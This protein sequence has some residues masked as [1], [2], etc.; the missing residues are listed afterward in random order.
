MRTFVLILTN[1]SSIHRQHGQ[2]V[3]HVRHAMY[4]A[5][6][7]HKII[8]MLRTKAHVLISHIPS[9]SKIFSRC[10]EE[11]RSPKTFSSSARTHAINSKGG[12]ADVKLRVK[13]KKV[14]FFKKDVL[15]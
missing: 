2:I 15:S 4:R 13:L 3:A 5:S 9:A 11:K 10:L 1:D 14:P 8:L 12:G 7:L 6:K